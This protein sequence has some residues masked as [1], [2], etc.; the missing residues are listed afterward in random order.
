[1][2][3]SYKE[4]SEDFIAQPRRMSVFSYKTR[5]K[6]GCPFRSLEGYT[7]FVF[8]SSYDWCFKRVV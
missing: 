4:N 7:S 3:I 6:A 8:I 5:E 2:S 1:M